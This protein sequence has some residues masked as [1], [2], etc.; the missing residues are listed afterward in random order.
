MVDTFFWASQAPQN[1]LFHYH[2][3][4]LSVQWQCTHSMGRTV[5]KNPGWCM[6]YGNQGK[7]EMS[8]NGQKDKVTTERAEA[9]CKHRQS[10]NHRKLKEQ[11]LKTYHR[12]TLV[13]LVENAGRVASRGNT[14]EDGKNWQRHEGE[15]RV[16]TPRHLRGD[17][18][19]V[20]Q[21]GENTKEEV[22]SKTWHTRAKY[23]NKTGNK[24]ETLN[25]DSTLHLDTFIKPGG[26][27]H[28]MWSSLQSGIT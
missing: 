15:Q 5:W 13:V 24:N 11:K 17:Q 20:E 25:R 7:T 4:S 16:Y 26:K 21:G 1:D 22:K 23:Q 18:E 9:T 14:E 6:C 28:R 3:L 12:E 27:T 2:N 10:T 19:Q 8:H